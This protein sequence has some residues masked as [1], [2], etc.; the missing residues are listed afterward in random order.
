MEV[1]YKFDVSV[2]IVN[3]N[4]G[5]YL[6]ETIVSLIEKTQD[7]SY[8][9]VLVDNNSNSADESIKFIDT[10]L[11]KYP[12]VKIIKSEINNGFGNANNIGIA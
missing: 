4:S 3:Y 11:S 8:E 1:N 6:K 2:I 7:I 12:N 9:I 5:D 10:E